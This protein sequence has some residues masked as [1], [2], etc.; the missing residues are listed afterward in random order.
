MTDTMLSQPAARTYRLAALVRSVLDGD[1]RVPHF[2][3]SFRWDARDVVKLFDSVLRGFPVGSVLLWQRDAPA[4]HAL[5]L[6]AI[7]LDV[8]ARPNALWV[9]DG[10]QRI[11]SLVNAVN[12]EA[13]DLDERFRLVYDLKSQ[14]VMHQKDGGTRDTVPLPVLFN[15]RELLLWGQKHPEIGDRILELNDVATRLQNFELPA[16]VVAEASQD[17]MQ[18]IFDR[19]NSS[20]KRLRRAEIFAALFAADEKEA[21]TAL[22]VS[23]IGDRIAGDTTFGKIDDNTV[24]QVVLARRGIDTTRDIRREFDNDAKSRSEFPGEDRDVALIEGE[25]ALR[26]AVAFLQNEAGIPHVAF[27]PYRFLLI[28]LSRLLAHFPAPHVRNQELI[29]RWLW[30]AALA[31]PE[32]FKGSSTTAIRALNAK[33]LPGHESAS[34]QGLL[35]AVGRDAAPAGPNLDR[36]RTNDSSTRIVLAA[37]W[38]QEP[39]SFKTGDRLLPTDIAEA[40]EGR[41]T[42]LNISLEI[43]SPTQLDGSHRGSAANRAL[44][45]DTPEDALDVLMAGNSPFISLEL[46]RFEDRVRKSHVVSD[47]AA[48]ALANGDFNDF[49]DLRRGDLDGVVR[50]FLERR[51]GRGLESTP[52]L[53]DFDFDD[54]RDDALD[55]AS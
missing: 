42:A 8:P 25:K 12:Q 17:M 7:T 46:S 40:L 52:P 24:L 31:G 45:I 41:S 50:S 22:T 11:T 23:A 28:T 15:L 19:M 21:D 36:F 49:L 26:A 1:V 53:E 33:V 20:G 5:Q 32:I 6:G 2:Q 16:S 10:Q 48:T 30:Q 4:N 47:A 27:L 3:R 39:R 18:E 54:D 55:S 37:M 44:S 38:D 43:A 14:T 34:V 29:S 35:T 13:W 51:T 9:V